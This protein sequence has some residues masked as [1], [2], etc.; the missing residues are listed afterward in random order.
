MKISGARS[1]YVDRL[2]VK[3]VQIRINFERMNGIPRHNASGTGKAPVRAHERARPN[4]F[5]ANCQAN[6]GLTG[7]R[8]VG[9]AG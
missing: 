4:K 3:T 1:T 9:L 7:W 6:V 8:A 5:G 2:V